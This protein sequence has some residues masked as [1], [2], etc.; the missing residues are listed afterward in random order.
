SQPVNQA[1]ERIIFA[2]NGDGT[3]TAVIQILYEGPS[4]SFSWLLPISTVPEGDELAVA[5]DLAFA[6]LQAA[7]NPQYNLTPR[8]EGTCRQSRGDSATSLVGIAPPIA[9]NFDAEEGGVSVDASGVVGQFAWS[10]ISLENPD[11]PDP[12][13]PALDWLRSNGYDV[14]PEAA[15]LVGPYLADGMHLLALRL[16]K[17][18][19]SGSIRPIRLSY[20]AAA[21]MIPIKLTAVAAN[22][23]M[24]VMTWALSNARAVPFNYNALEL[25]EARIN[26]FNAASTYNQV[27]TEAAD[28][29]GGQGFV[30][31]FAGPSAQLANVVWP[32]SDEAD[33]Q[34]L[35]GRTYPS[36]GELLGSLRNYYQG[37]SGFWDAVR[38]VVT[39]PQGVSFEDFKA[40]PNCF[41][42]VEFSPSSLF[43][44]IETDVIDPVRE[45]QSLIDRTPYTTRLYS[46]LSAAEMTLDPVFVFN[47]DLP[48]V[49]NIHRAERVIE[50]NPNV[51]QSDAPW[52]IELP[53]GS[54]L[55][56]SARSVNQWPSALD[57]APA[58]F[59]VLSRSSSGPGR[60]VEDNAD[61][62]N[63]QLAAYNESLAS[64]GSASPAASSDRG[65]FC[66]LARAPDP[67]GQP[68]APLGLALCGLIGGVWACRR[69]GQRS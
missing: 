19:D 48:E 9:A 69:R 53:Q 1:A 30:T 64:S 36:L 13:A 32:S 16:T 46:T 18:S 54:L 11:V 44:A 6:R 56:G 15:A 17:G 4:E 10:V 50:C 38:R 47:P 29:A 23:D 61:E 57:A 20:A 24:G 22:R 27:V 65:G 35:R 28:A 3:I 26:W 39:L 2:D 66:S 5:S 42:R 14:T 51:Y 59:R 45:V 58:N 21:P 8:V 67:S 34:S 55:R 49:D 63:T 37:W 68:S 7:T 31:E 43:D 25:N 52:R 62:I 60:V 40:C 41:P 33:W 12:S